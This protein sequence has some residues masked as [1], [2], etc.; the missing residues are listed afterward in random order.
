MHYGLIGTGLM[1]VPLGHRLL[2]SGASLTVY[3]RTAAKAA[4]LVQAGA[5]LAPTPATVL[6]Q[7][8]CILLV[9]TDAAAI[10]E[11]LLTEEARSQIPGKTLV[12]MGTIAPQ[13]SRDICAQVEAA[14]GEYWEA[15]V[16]GSIPE[17]RSGTLIVMVGSTPQQ[18]SQGQPLLQCFSPHPHAIG[19][20]GQAMALKLALNQL[21]AGLTSTFALSLAFVQ[22]QGVDVEQFMAI[23]RDSAVYAPTFDKKLQRMVDRDF[24]R[25]N[26]P[27]QHLLKDVDLF[28][29][30]AQD[31][32]LMT[33]SL[34]GIGQILEKA[35]TL[36]LAQGDYS[37]LFAAINPLDHPI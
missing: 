15:P 8:D 33:D 30:E 25:P 21:I 6:A 12:Q 5:S 18:F 37:A 28:L 35:L 2:E 24:D 31:L 9:L 26:F 14:G 3:N 36:G 29:T 19:A 34:Q 13:E 22:R 10:A 11:T 17:A 23:V 32:N 7:A 20:V 27:T 16:L 4:S 1:G